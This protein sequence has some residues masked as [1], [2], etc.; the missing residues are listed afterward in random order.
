MY[1]ID[2]SFFNSSFETTDVIEE[3]CNTTY[4]NLIMNSADQ[5]PTACCGECGTSENQN[6]SD[7]RNIILANTNGI[8]AKHYCLIPTTYQNPLQ[9]GDEIIFQFNE[10]HELSTVTEVGDFVQFR[11]CKMSLSNEQ[12]PV[13]VRKVSEYDKEKIARNIKDEER[14]KPFFYKKIEEYML[15]MKLVDVHFQFDRKKI[16]FFYTAD[17]RVDFRQLAKSLAAEFRTRIELRQI[18]VRDEAKIV[19]GIGS[20]GREY[21]CSSFMNSFKHITTQHACV[22][23]TSSNLTKLSGPCGKLKCCLSFESDE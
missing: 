17:G 11:R 18:G 9:I 20:C 15:E 1:N 22:P 13:F 16:Y 8:L 5:P 3:K 4:Q 19:G 23:H 6:I 12:I 2:L 21:C 14:A 7:K 10:Y